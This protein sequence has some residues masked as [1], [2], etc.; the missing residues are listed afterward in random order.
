MANV[1]RFLLFVAL[2]SGIVAALFFWRLLSDPSTQAALPTATE[3]PPK[4][5]GP[6]KIGGSLSA[7]QALDQAFQELI[8]KARPSVVS[9]TARGNAGSDAR[10]GLLRPYYGRRGVVE[11]PP[12]LGSGVVV[13]EQGHI[14]TNLHVIQGAELI[15]VMLGDGR[16]LPAKV[17]G[18]D[19]FTDIAVLQV[20]AENLV[21]MPLGD[22]D[23]VRAGQIVF[24]IGNPY[25]LHETVTQGI[26]SGIGRRSSSEL[27]NEFFQT[28]TAVNPGNSG[29]PLINLDGEIIGINNAIHSQSGAWQG[30]S[31]AIP[32]NTAR[33][34]FDDIRAYGRVV[35]TWFGVVTFPPGVLPPTQ[36]RAGMSG[37]GIYFTSENSPAERSGIQPGDII[38]EFNGKAI[39]DTIDLRNRVAETEAGQTVQVKI[40]RQGTELMLAVM[41]DEYPRG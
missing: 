34:V 25:G 5:P 41:M 29:G 20:P 16:S 24:A 12:Q 21:P 9:I 28:D 8:S 26:I 2:L 30:I 23:K 4:L 40:V 36:N 27:V 31:F 19:P 3:V 33:R 1:L 39:T 7:L 22:S 32:S 35:R 18:S 37:V 6:P 11:L 14:I 15:E 38:V 17:L 10:I 13:S